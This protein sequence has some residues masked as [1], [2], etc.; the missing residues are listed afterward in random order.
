MK[1][2]LIGS[3]AVIAMLAQHNIANAGSVTVNSVVPDTYNLFNGS[4]GDTGS[5]SIGDYDFSGDG[6][7]YAAHDDLNGYHI[8]PGNSNAYMA[9]TGS[10]TVTLS[11]P[12]KTVSLVWASADVWNNALV[13]NLSVNGEVVQGLGLGQALVSFFSDT[14]FSSFTLTSSQPAFEFQLDPPSSGAAPEP[15]TWAMML[16][17][18]AGLGYASMSCRKTVRAV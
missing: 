8:G 15:A 17:G 12:T 6:V 5:F 10:E 1:S 2:I 16:L 18:F 14:P 4:V 9:V 11:A 7:V 13:G 3:V